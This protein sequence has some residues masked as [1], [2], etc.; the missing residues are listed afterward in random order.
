MPARQPFDAV[1][2]SYHS[3]H[4][5]VAHTH[6]GVEL[7]LLDA[8]I[9]SIAD[10]YD[11]MTARRPYQKPRPHTAVMDILHSEAGRKHDPD[12][13]KAFS[14]MIETSPLRAGTA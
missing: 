10:S 4:Q 7:D 13:V 5:R 8:R 2:G 14:A 12:L 6:P 11:A 9:A 1:E 3:R